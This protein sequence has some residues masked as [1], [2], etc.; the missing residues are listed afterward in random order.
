[1]SKGKKV[2]IEKISGMGPWVRSSGYHNEHLEDNLT[3]ELSDLELWLRPTTQEELS[4]YLTV[5]KFANFIENLFPPCSVVAQGSTGT[6]T[7][8][9]TSDIDLIITN[10]PETEDGNHLLKKLSK[11][12]WKSQL[13]VQSFVIPKAKVPII[14]CVERVY[15]YHLDICIGN[16]NGLLNVPRV[17]NYLTHYPQIRPLLMFMKAITFI[18]G[19]DDPCNGGFGSNH[20]LN[21]VF[22]AIQA[23]PEAKS[24]GELLIKLLDCIGN[25]FNYFTCGIT[26]VNGGCLFSKYKTNT[27]DPKHPQSFVFEDP[28]MYNIFFGNNTTRMPNL[29]TIFQESLAKIHSEAVND[30]SYLS[31]VLG[32]LDKIVERRKQILKIAKLLD[33]P[34]EQFAD[35]VNKTK[36]STWIE[37]SKK[38]AKSKS[39]PPKQSKNHTNKPKIPKPNTEKHH[40]KEYKGEIHHDSVHKRQTRNKHSEDNE[41]RKITKIKRSKSVGS[42]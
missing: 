34:I 37:P 2:T 13:V 8:L 18:T 30:S 19:N 4:R 24:T 39:V 31:L 16:I 12:F 28:Q 23:F 5:R 10:L 29:V 41:K 32:S 15:G 25:K 1:M 35:K 17:H 36:F 21:L 38:K 11:D 7:Y 6:D 20:L 26:I 42:H 22:F 14:K 33:S 27:L 9:P 40:K 3:E